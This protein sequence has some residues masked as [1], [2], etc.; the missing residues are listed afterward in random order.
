[1]G[2]ATTVDRRARTGRA[3]VTARRGLRA[4]AL[5]TALVIVLAGCTSEQTLAPDPAGA[6]PGYP[7]YTPPA[8][9]PDGVSPGGTPDA[10][11]TPDDAPVGPGPSPTV[12]PT[13]EPTLAPTVTPAPSQTPSPTTE[14]SAPSPTATPTTAP[15]TPVPTTPPTST[16]PTTPPTPTTPAALTLQTQ[17][18]QPQ[19]GAALTAPP[20]VNDLSVAVT[21]QTAAGGP[22]QTEA[23]LS[24]GADAPVAA[25]RYVAS[26]TIARS[27]TV[28]STWVEGQD[29]GPAIALAAR[30]TLVVPV[31]HDLAETCPSGGVRDPGPPATTSASAVAPAAPG[32]EDGLVINPEPA[33]GSAQLG[34]LPAGDYTA[35]VA[36]HL[37]RD[38]GIGT[39]VV[40]TS[41]VVPLTVTD[42]S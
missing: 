22:L 17:T 20:A 33:S 6:E 5:V 38:G 2:A 18:W 15:P 12:T 21:L 1:M 31:F 9:S 42:A 23:V 19:C 35:V 28:V 16:S 11:G 24:N 37:V 4:S 10:V 34:S 29:A 8:T 13:A 14:P 26:V 25:E 27:G 39:S 32:D 3:M 36:I 30:G 40:A 41:G 7:Q